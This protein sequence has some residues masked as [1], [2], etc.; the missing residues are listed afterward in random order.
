MNILVIGGT[1]L[2]G[3]KV[4]VRLRNLGHAVVSASPSSGVNTLTGEGLDKAMEGVDTVID[5]ANSPIFVGREVAEFFE[6]AGHNTGSAEKK[7]G[8]RKHIALSV[9]G[10][11]RLQASDYFVGKLAQ[12]KTIRES[13]VPFTIVRSTQFFEFLNGIAQHSA[14][15]QEIRLST[16]LI[17]P[18]ASDDVADQVV[19]HALAEPANDIAEIAG[20][21]KLPMADLVRRFLTIIQDPREVTGDRSALYFGAMLDENTLVPGPA[22]TL[23]HIDF[24]AWLNQ[25]EFARYG[26][27]A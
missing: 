4:V 17:Q 15:G 19:A 11:D 18:I 21:V 25:S 26:A 7:A 14:A 10:T 13:G 3:S 24:Q 5:L 1:G 12:E 6:K 9:V 8:V 16:A 20:P 23:G 27:T 2:I 22:A